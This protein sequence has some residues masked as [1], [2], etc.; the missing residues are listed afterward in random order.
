MPPCD[1]P[2]SEYNLGE[3]ANCVW[4]TIKDAWVGVVTHASAATIPEWI[5]TVLSG[6][7]ALYILKLLLWRRR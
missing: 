2:V 4:V 7:V 1:K 3:A 5:I 6:L